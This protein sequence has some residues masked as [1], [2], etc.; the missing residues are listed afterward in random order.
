M[1]TC[2]CFNLDKNMKVPAA[3]MTQSLADNYSGSEILDVVYVVPENEIEEI[4]D[5]LSK[6][7]S[8]KF[9]LIYRPTVKHNDIDL[10]A[11]EHPHWA[12][13]IIFDRL[14]LGSTL[15]DYDKVIYFDCDM[16]AVKDIQP[17]LDF[18]LIGK[19]AATPDISHSIID[20]D[21][22]HVVEF[23][24]G[25]FIADLRWWRDSGVEVEFKNHL[26]N[27]EM[28]IF[29]EQLVFN[30]YTK[31]VYQPTPQTFNFLV[32][33]RDQN[34][35]HPNWDASE[36]KEHYKRAIIIHFAGRDK[37]WN[38]KDDKSKIGRQWRELASRF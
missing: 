27:I 7:E 21:D 34:Y 17:I 16:L 9:N 32:F 1:K 35:N 24:N 38:Y 37:P 18:K 5:T 10:S 33:K 23:N 14:F 26:K 30:L 3:V 22:P 15:F 19:F 28:N 20:R 36:I 12:T 2:L 8:P 29:K 25:F 4:A 31:D 6:V 13:N 11:I